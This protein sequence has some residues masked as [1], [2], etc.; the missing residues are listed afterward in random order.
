[1]PRRSH[2]DSTTLSLFKQKYLAKEPAEKD[3]WFKNGGKES[4][5]E[6]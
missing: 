3:I 5:T 6:S 1:M 4:G 2:K